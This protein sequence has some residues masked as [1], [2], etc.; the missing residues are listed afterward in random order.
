MRSHRTRQGVHLPAAPSQ[1]ATT[2]RTEAF[3]DNRFGTTLQ[4]DAFLRLEAGR[5][6]KPKRKP[7][8]APLRFLK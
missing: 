3:I 5:T 2:N 6:R 8:L 7:S 4:G 1:E